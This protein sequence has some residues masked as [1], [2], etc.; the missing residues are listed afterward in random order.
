[1][2]LMD[3]VQTK[4][5]DPRSFSEQRCEFR[6]DEGSVRSNMRLCNIR[7][8][9]G[10]AGIITSKI[11]YLNCIQ[12]VYLYD[13]NEI[14]DQN[15]N[16]NY[17]LLVKQY[18][19]NNDQ[20]LSES[21]LAEISDGVLVDNQ[22]NILYKPAQQFNNDGFLYLRD[23][24]PM[25]DSNKYLFSK[26]FKNLRLVIEFTL[27]NVGVVND[28]QKTGGAVSGGLNL[29]RP[30]LVVDELM[31]D[32]NQMSGFK[33]Y[34]WLSVEVDRFFLENAAAAS[35]SATI[36]TEAFRDKMLDSLIMG[37]QVTDVALARNNIGIWYYPSLKNDTYD[38]YVNGHKLLPYNGIDN[39]SLRTD[40]TMMVL[41]NYQ[42][43]YGDN[44][45]YTE[46]AQKQSESIATDRNSIDLYYNGLT[47]VKINKV[48]NEL[49]INF[50]RD[51]G[52]GNVNWNQQGNLLM[53]GRCQKA[54]IPSGNE[55]K[56]VY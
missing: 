13:G 33:S 22:N 42:C 44:L 34:N 40:Y 43:P 1:M 51:G 46:V 27:S 20:K 29:R 47:A 7:F 17:W 19:K 32:T 26:H 52:A 24:L 23:V 3:N 50:S 18:M 30:F 11:G 10:P 28:V 2:S 54:V 37:L 6:L 12:A 45:Y 48:I 25:L 8:D 21:N 16:A 36:R 14:L 5:Y 38:L 4:I 15:I 56:V 39:P 49:Q 35:Q 31:D 41:G 9:V 53:F 55:Y